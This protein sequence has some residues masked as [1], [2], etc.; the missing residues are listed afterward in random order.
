MS[1]TFAIGD[2]HGCYNALQT[3]INS[4]PILPDDMVITLGDYVDRGPSSKEVINWLIARHASNRLVAIRGNHDLMFAE[5][6]FDADTQNR[7]LS[8]GGIQTLMSYGEE[9]TIATLDDVPANHFEFI[10]DIALRYYETHSHIFV[11]AMLSPRLPLSEQPDDVIY[12]EKFRVPEQHVSGKI[13]V[14]GHTAQKT[15]API[16]IGHAIC[17]DTWV[18]GSG[19]LTCLEVSSGEYWQAKESGE[20]RQRSL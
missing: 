5:A 1:R 3:L 9:D 19:W 7:W 14:C 13:M 15:G 10:E 6:R 20:F 11:H 18:Y 17:I 12:W 4:V 16:S 2:I 8:V